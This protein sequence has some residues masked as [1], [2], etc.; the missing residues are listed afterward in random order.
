MSDYRSWASVPAEGRQAA[1]PE[2]VKYVSAAVISGIQFAAERGKWQ[3]RIERLRAAYAR[4]G[5]TEE[6]ALEDRRLRTDI[7]RLAIERLAERNDT[8][9]IVEIFKDYNSVGY[10]F[11]GKVVEM[12]EITLRSDDQNP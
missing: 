5:Q 7:A 9:G 11:L 1:D 12:I 4:Y 10:D 3:S 8:Q 6:N 2:I